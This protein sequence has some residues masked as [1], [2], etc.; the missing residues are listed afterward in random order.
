MK[1]GKRWSSWK[2]LLAGLPLLLLAPGCVTDRAAVERNLMAQQPQ[3]NEGVAESYRVGCPDIVEL[4]IDQ[5]T[6]FS[7]HYEITADG[8]IN[9]G[10]YGKPRIEGRTLPE[11]AKLIAREIGVS[12]ASVRV[13]VTEYRSQHVLLFGEVTG[14]QRSVPYRGPETVLD[15]LQRVGGITAGAAPSDVYVVRPHIGA[16]HRPEVFHVDLDAI[17]LKQDHR[18]NLRLVAFDQI[19]VGETRQAKIENALPPWAR[20]IVQ[21]VWDTKPK[22][23]TP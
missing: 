21:A 7:G 17:V 19:Y 12:P 9:L 10:D 11:V 23:T 16:N 14:K 13:F 5:R 3:R 1:T 22:N 2:S 6:E 20:W 18:T 4:E 8:R 15:L